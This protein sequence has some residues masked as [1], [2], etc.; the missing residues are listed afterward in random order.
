MKLTSNRW[1]LLT[2]LSSP[3]VISLQQAQ[4][5][6]YIGENEDITTTAFI[7]CSDGIILSQTQ[8]NNANPHLHAQFGS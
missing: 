3:A 6:S 2:A 5:V 4:I 7:S 8:D 1:F